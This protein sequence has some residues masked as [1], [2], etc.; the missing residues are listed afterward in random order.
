MEPLLGTNYIGIDVLKVKHMLKKELPSAS[1]K[2]FIPQN[3]DDYININPDGAKQAKLY[4]QELLQILKSGGIKADDYRDDDN[5]AA[6]LVVQNGKMV[7]TEY[8]KAISSNGSVY[9]RLFN[10]DVCSETHYCQ[11][12]HKIFP[13]KNKN[14]NDLGL[15][16]KQRNDAEV[17][18]INVIWKEMSKDHKYSDPYQI[19]IYSQKG[20]CNSCLA[21]C[22]WYVEQPPKNVI[23]YVHWYGEYERRDKDVQYGFPGQA[24]SKETGYYSYVIYPS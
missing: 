22:K 4:L 14:N 12:I 1:N 17:K 3:F 11:D 9:G 18:A 23:I 7:K 2:Y 5:N 24:I 21:L 6:F 16:G 10:E 20:M 13:N 15:I 8:N 19:H